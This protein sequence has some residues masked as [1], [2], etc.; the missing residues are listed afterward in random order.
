MGDGAEKSNEIQFDQYCSVYLLKRL[1][2]IKEH[3]YI[4]IDDYYSQEYVELNIS[5]L[6]SLIDALKKLKEVIEL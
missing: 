2:G 5:S 3:R 6:D 4:I 1:I